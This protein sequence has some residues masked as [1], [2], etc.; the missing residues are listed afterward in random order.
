METAPTLPDF[1]LALKPDEFQ[2]PVV[3]AAWHNE[4]QDRGQ[5]N[6]D[7]SWD[8]NESYPAKETGAN[9]RVTTKHQQIFCLKR[10]GSLCP[11]IFVNRTLSPAKY[12]D[13]IVQF[14][15]M[16]FASAKGKV[17]AKVRIMCMPLIYIYIYLFSEFIGSG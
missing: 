7:R 11:F 17:F 4:K 16:G 15:V 14:P 12:D 8:L 13:S 2:L 1:A 10:E 3:D 5:V 9:G 6:G